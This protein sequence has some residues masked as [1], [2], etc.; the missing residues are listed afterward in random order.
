MSPSRRQFLAAAAVSPLVADA[1]R[2]PT[3]GADPHLAESR[4]TATV[5]R[6]DPDRMEPWIVVQPDALR[7]NVGVLNR[8]SNNRPLMAV[9]KNN[10][11]GLGLLEVAR[12]LDADP[13]VSGFGVVKVGEALALRSA[14]IRKPILLLALWDDAE[15]EELVRQDVT[16]SLCV[17]DA[18]AR[19]ARAAARA[20]KGARAQLYIDTGMS[21]MGIPYHAAL[22][23]IRQAAQESQITLSG[24]LTELTEDRAFDTDQANRLLQLA[25]Q[26]RAAGVQLGGPLHAA[27]SHAVFNHPDTL[28]DAVRP[29]IALFGAYPTDEGNERSIATL[30]VAFS[31]R[32]RVVRVEQMRVGDTV[33][34]GRRFRADA[35]TWIATIPVGHADGYPRRAVNGC[36]ILIGAQTYP[37]IGA[38]SASHCIVNL[39]AETTVKVGDVC[40]L[41]GPE[42]PDIHPNALAMAAGVSV[43]D[44]LMHLAQELPRSLA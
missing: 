27:S 35:P 36:R 6:A 42:H 30:Q 15:G 12:I 10:G 39:G 28:L 22:P 41:V 38:V 34:Y 8:L 9:V 29:G 11:Y 13:R 7:A 20:Q 40:T 33:S 18:P 21:R 5:R 37:V 2:L 23:V 31:L 43:Y 1:L 26:A 14:G 4:D 16:L 25:A 24:M 44:I 17:A 19:V 3:G 32:A